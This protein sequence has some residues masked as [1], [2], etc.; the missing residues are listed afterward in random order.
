MTQT[1]DEIGCFPVKLTVKSDIN[2]VTHATSVM[3][4]VENML[5]TLSGL[6]VEVENPE[7][8]PVIV[9]VRAQ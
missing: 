4:Q 6:S 5:P 7:S 3:M 2:N 8:D 1:F 9:N